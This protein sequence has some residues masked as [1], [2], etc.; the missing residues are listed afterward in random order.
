[1]STTIESLELEIKSNS[2]KAAN[3]ITALADSLRTLKKAT[4]GGLG[5]GSIANDMGSLNSATKNLKNNLNKL[6]DIKNKVAKSSIHLGI[7]LAS[8]YIA[9]K[10]LGS[11]IGSVINESTEY[12]ENVNLFTVS[13]GQYAGEMTRYAETVSDVMGIDTSDWMRAQGVFMTISTGFGIASDRAATMSKNLTQLGYDI[14]SF[15]NISVDNAMDKL[16]SGLAGELEPLRAIGYDLSQAKLEAT[17]LALG[18]DK[19]VSSMTQAEKAQLRYY[20]IMTQVTQVHGDMARTLDDP[21]NQLRVLKA[22]LNMA[23]RE[24]GNIFIPALNAILPVAIAVTKVIRS[25]ANIIASLFG[26]E[27]PEIDDST[28]KV[29]ENTDAMTENL[30]EGQE[31]AKKLKSYMLGFDELN[32]ITPNTDVAEDTSGEF[33]FELPEYD[34]MAG[35]VESKVNIIVEEMKEWLGI[36]DDIDTWAE[37]LDTRLGNIL[38]TVGLIGISI[39]TWKIS[40]AIDNSIKSIQK[41]LENPVYTVAIGLILSITGV[42]ITINGIE[43]AIKNGLDGFNFAEIVGGALLTGVGAILLG[44]KIAEWLGVAF[45]S[46]AIPF[47]LARIG[48]HLGVTTSGAVGVAIG[49]GITAIIAGIPMYFMG[50]Y[51]ACKDGL[52]W[53]NGLLISLGSTLVGAG[54]GFFIGGPVGAGIGALIGLAVGAITELVILIVQK[55]DEISAW[56]KTNVVE[57][58]ATFFQPL[59][60][61]CTEAWAWLEEKLFTPMNEAFTEVKEYATEKFTEIKDGVVTAFTTIANKVVE[62]KDKIVEIFTALKWAFNEYVWNPI[63]EKVSAFYDENIKPIVDGFRDAVKE[64][65]GFFK[66]FFEVYIEQRIDVLV[67]RFKL[68]GKGVVDFISGLFTGAI[69]SILSWVEDKINTF[70]GLINGAIELVNKIPGVSISPISEINI[71]LLANGGYVDSG[72]MFIANEAG[73]ELVGN[74]GRRTAVAN[75]EQIVESVS[76]GVAEAN[77]EQNVL[78]RE[79]NALLR[80]ILEKDSGVYLDGRS[81]SDSVDKYKREQG[82]VLITGGVL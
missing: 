40:T 68:F 80:A 53:L 75:N 1:M 59:I 28:S 65:W 18:I 58:L 5:L 77:S 44:S 46:P 13:M 74:I 39:A 49:A 42:T 17:A 64:I 11:A 8:T 23:A 72:Q 26:Y 4:Q 81:L 50:I 22:Q 2:T 51:D 32:I 48:K 60:D 73:P 38:E 52:D 15:Y 47:A 24:I 63:V 78:L 76:V 16:K 33:D 45:E 6:A 19:S 70:I 55:W 25:L 20:A 69:N 41:L 7:K 61:S 21:A 30:Q 57:P 71:P 62:I 29:V 14:S 10:K 34:F 79:Q 66:E 43:D 82:R 27:A 12:I 35:L 37:L 3:G 56:T 9:V 31:A 67:D 54:I 36:T